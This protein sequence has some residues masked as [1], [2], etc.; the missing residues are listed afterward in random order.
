MTEHPSTREPDSSNNEPATNGPSTNEPSNNE[1]SNNEPSNNG[2]STSGPTGSRPSGLRNPKAAV[3][4]VGAGAL[5]AQG[6]V[7][8]LAIQPIRVLGGHLTGLAIAVIVVLAVT[9]FGLAGLLRRSWAWHGG[10]LVQVVL[11]VSGFVFHASLAVLGVLFGLLWIY[12]LHVR[13][14]VLR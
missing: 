1:P 3:R 9:C 8:L 10:S 12:V 7:L 5:A 14:N 4:G 13:R 6:V 11:L 2:T